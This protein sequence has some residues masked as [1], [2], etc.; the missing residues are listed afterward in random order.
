MQAAA[1]CALAVLPFTCLGLG[2]GCAASQAES[3]C[4]DSVPKEAEFPPGETQLAARVGRIGWG[5][6]PAGLP[7]ACEMAVLEGDP[8]REML[9]TVRFRTRGDFVLKPHWHP[10]N[11]RVTVLE[12]RIGVGFGTEVDREMVTWFEAGDYYVNAKEVVHF[13]LTDGPTVVQITGI[14]PWK[15]N[16]IEPRP[17]GAKREAPESRR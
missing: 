1:R 4:P 17:E 8:R 2:A 3:S 7:A 6:C 12:G 16:L 14:G 10:G 11:E 15:A 13:V 9:F 5:A